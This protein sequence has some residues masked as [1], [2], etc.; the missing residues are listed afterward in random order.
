MGAR[1]AH[2][3]VQTPTLR[4]PV[5]T[6]EFLYLGLSSHGRFRSQAMNQQ[7]TAVGRE[8]KMTTSQ[9]AIESLPGELPRWRRERV[10]EIGDSL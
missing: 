2:P 5:S 7:P 4:L 6:L 9:S 1:P 3:A 10:V 8:T